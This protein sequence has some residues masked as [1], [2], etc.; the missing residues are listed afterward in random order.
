MR[1][2]TRQVV[3]E[4]AE[5]SDPG[6]DPSKQEN[7]D[8]SAYFETPL[9]HLAVLCDGMGGHASGQRASRTAV[10]VIGEVVGAAPEGAAPARVLRDA[11]EQAARAVFALGANVPADVR[12]GST[13]VALLLHQGGA[14]VAHVGDSRLYLLHEGQVVRVTKDHSMV[15]EMVDAGVLPADQAV[16]HPE[17]NKITRALGMDARVDAE[18]RPT[19]LPIVPGDVLILTSDG[20]TD[21]LLDEEIGRIALTHLASGPA[22][23]CQ[24]LVAQANARGGH[25]NITVQMLHVLEIPERGSAVTVPAE[26]PGGPDATS[27]GDTVVGATVADDGSRRPF[28]AA[29]TLVDAS[30][31]SEGGARLTEPGVVP[32]SPRRFPDSEPRQFREAAASARSPLLIVLALSLLLVLLAVALWL[33]RRSGAQEDTDVPPPLPR[34]S[35]GRTIAPRPSGALVPDLSEEEPPAPVAP[36]TP[37]GTGARPP[38]S[39]TS[40]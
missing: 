32:E 7:E 1:R 22:V 36:P 5:L 14:E 2:S 38:T 25:D 6:R 13:C 35:T 33:V 21:L 9:G 26:P 23:A 37:P 17:A 15:Q 39:P 31:G 19:P 11:L 10:E 40:R 28:R 34:A 27:R 24:E 20:L 4:F 30:L 12:P 3:I 29:P 8:S 16:H 18:V